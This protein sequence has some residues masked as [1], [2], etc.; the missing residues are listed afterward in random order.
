MTDV[1]LEGGKKKSCLSIIPSNSVTSN[2]S[3]VF[4]KAT[5]AISIPVWSKRGQHNVLTSLPRP[6]PQHST[7]AEWHPL[8]V[9]SQVVTGSRPQ[10]KYFCIFKWNIVCMYRVL[11]GSEP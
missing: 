10:V 5:R 1:F 2:P 8:V 6:R 4:R 3:M 11:Q 7:V 9:I